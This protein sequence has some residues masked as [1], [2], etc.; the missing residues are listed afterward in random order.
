MIRLTGIL[1]LLTVLPA[2]ANP[3]VDFALGVL[4]ESRKDKEEAG[5]RFESARQADPS[6]FPLVKRAVTASLERGDR[7]AAVA[8]YRDLAKARPKDLDVQLIYADFL[9]EQGRGD[10][11]AN[12]I[13]SETLEKALAENPQ[14]PEIIRRL[15]MQASS[16]GDESKQRKLLEM[17]REDDP[18]S[19]MLFSSL[20]MYL[21]DASE[22]KSKATVDERFL[23]ASE[24]HPESPAFARTAS[25]HFRTSGR[26]EQAIEILKRH[27]QANPSSLALR[28][29][30]GVVLFAAKREDE[31]EAV[32]K[33]VISIHPR[34]AAAHQ[35]LAKFYRLK[36]RPAEARYHA[37]ELLKIRGGSPTEFLSLADEWL[38]ADAPREARL[39]L[40]KAVFDHPENGPLADKLA[41][42]TR[43]DP[44]TRESASRLFREAEAAATPDQKKDPDFLIESAETLIAEG[45]SKAAEDRL[46]AAIKSYPPEANKQTAAALRRLAGLWENEKRNLD[47]ARSLRQR[48]DSLD[49]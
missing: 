8:L 38:A 42:A 7:P 21:K 20:T 26:M 36:N 40:E 34:M 48:A 24:S 39:L 44:E 33:E 17:L 29:R 19:A 4:A 2:A 12:K 25:D 15:F 32:L 11:L 18:G 28:A 9:L 35:P 27:V 47:A 1:A 46:R 49:R 37:G 22:A 30:L 10:A 3:K 14:N 31:G 16:S 5:R 23:L 41:I 13:A 6:A 45:Q 43:R